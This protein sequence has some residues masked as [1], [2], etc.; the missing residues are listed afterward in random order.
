MILR[1]LACPHQHLLTR[2]TLLFQRLSTL[3]RVESGQEGVQFIKQFNMLCSDTISCPVTTAAAC[4]DTCWCS[5]CCV[6]TLAVRS[7]AMLNVCV[8]VLTLK[9]PQPC[10]L[11]MRR[12]VRLLKNPCL[13]TTCNNQ[14]SCMKHLASCFQKHQQRL[15]MSFQERVSKMIRCKFITMHRDDIGRLPV[16][17]RAQSKRPEPP[18]PQNIKRV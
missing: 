12:S 4:A 15:L 1:A 14:N 2:V 10:T 6:R 18:S 9:V 3:D 13:L 7:Q 5:V 11:T 17:S 8:S 16:V